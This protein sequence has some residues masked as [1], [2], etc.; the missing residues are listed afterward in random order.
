MNDN[1]AFLNRALDLL[2]TLLD[3]PLV[4]LPG[5]DPGGSDGPT[6][7]R[8]KHFRPELSDPIASL[9]EEVGR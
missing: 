7:L 1:D 5:G 3:D 9:L 6:E 8:L 4:I 2:T